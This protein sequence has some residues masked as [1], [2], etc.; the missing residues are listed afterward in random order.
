MLGGAVFARNAGAAFFSTVSLQVNGVLMG[1]LSSPAQIS[2]VISTTELTR[3]YI[4]TTGAAEQLPYETTER[5]YNSFGIAKAD[6]SNR[7]AFSIVYKPPIGFL[8]TMKAFPGARITLTFNVAPEYGSR[9]LAPVKTSDTLT[10]QGKDVS[11]PTADTDFRVQLTSFK[12]YAAMMTPLNN[13]TIPSNVIVPMYEIASSAHQIPSGL[14]ADT[15][16]TISFNVPSS[17]F[18]IG[19]AV[20]DATAGTG[21]VKH[22]KEL[23]TFKFPFVKHLSVNYAGYQGGSGA[24]TNARNEPERP[25]ADFCHSILASQQGRAAAVSMTN[26][27]ISPIYLFRFAKPANDIS[28][29]ATV[30]ISFATNLTGAVNVFC[31]AYYQSTAALSYDNSGMVTGASYAYAS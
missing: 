30:R 23:S 8:R 16:Q 29:S 1:T 3:D 7:S 4:Q 12:Y 18:K 20:Q 13:P 17:T 10:V 5:S 9:V 14:T 19:I 22:D 6:G 15:L 21:N 27:V 2:G 11:T 31:F 25:Y 28:S 24:Y 26:W